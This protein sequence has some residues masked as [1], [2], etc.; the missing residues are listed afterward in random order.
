MLL[1]STLSLSLVA[2]ALSSLVSGAVIIPNAHKRSEGAS[3]K[4]VHVTG[5]LAFE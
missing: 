4:F 2:A 3:G 1:K 5:K